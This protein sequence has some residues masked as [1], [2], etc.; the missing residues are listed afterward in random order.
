MTVIKVCVSLPP[1]SFIVYR[2][3][4]RTDT[5][6]GMGTKE[7]QLERHSL[8][9]IIALLCGLHTMFFS[10]FS[11]FTSYQPFSSPPP[12]SLLLSLQSFYTQF[13]SLLFIFPPFLSVLSLHRPLRL[14]GCALPRCLDHVEHG[15]PL[16]IHHS[17]T[18]KTARHPGQR[19]PLQFANAKAGTHTHSLWPRTGR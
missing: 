2:I 1:V 8:S 19:P 7:R 14:A 12:L 18:N 4:G 15:R 17:G 5:P 6:A 13:H 11:T 16:N 9:F 10:F 3:R